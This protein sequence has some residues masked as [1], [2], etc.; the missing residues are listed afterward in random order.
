MPS[1]THT[2]EGATPRSLGNDTLCGYLVAEQRARGLSDEQFATFLGVST[3][4]W[5]EFGCGADPWPAAVLARVLQRF[6][7]ALALAAVEVRRRAEPGDGWRHWHA[8]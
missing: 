3:E 2:S 1:T 6:P 8:A 4:A 5:L 7:D